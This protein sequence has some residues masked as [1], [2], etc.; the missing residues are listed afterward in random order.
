MQFSIKVV[1]SLVFL[2]GVLAAPVPRPS[3]ADGSGLVELATRAPVWMNI[4]K[5]SIDE[6]SDNAHKQHIMGH[7]E[8][9]HPRS[10]DD[11]EELVTRGT[12][13]VVELSA[14]EPI[15]WMNIERHELREE[16]LTKRKQHIMNIAGHDEWLREIDESEEIGGLHRRDEDI[17]S[18]ALNQHHWRVGVEVHDNF[19]FDLKP[20]T[21][22]TL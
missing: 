11:E 13:D 17:Q 18:R 6:S 22:P 8:W 21:H 19:R 14:R 16:N 15:H 12:D 7:D 2:T 3:S 4:E 10:F 5:H 1:L 9:L 20:Q